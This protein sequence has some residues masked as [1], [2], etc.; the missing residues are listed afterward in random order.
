MLLT[1]LKVSVCILAYFD[2]KYSVGQVSETFTFTLQ[3]SNHNHIFA[4]RHSDWLR[5]ERPGSWGSSAGRD[6]NILSS[7]LSRPTLESTQPPFKCV[8]GA[9][10]SEVKR[11]GRK[12]DDSN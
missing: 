7:T 2:V 10:S 3:C 5:A 11:M 9:L 4:S 8:P 6:K 12:A 1:S